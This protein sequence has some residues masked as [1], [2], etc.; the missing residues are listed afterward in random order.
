VSQ[1][2]TAQ[3]VAD[4]P[5][6]TRKRAGGGRG[7][8]ALATPN[9]TGP[10]VASVQAELARLGYDV[11]ADGVFGPL[12]DAAVRAFQTSAGLDS[13]GVVGPLTL[14]ALARAVAGVPAV[15][16]P[17][18]LPVEV[19]RRSALLK[20]LRWMIAQE[21]LI[22]YT[23]GDGRLQALATPY[24]SPLRTDCSGSI[25]IACAWAE[26]PDPNG[27]GLNVPRG[28]TGTMLTYCKKIRRADAQPGDF[29]VLGD[30]PGVHAC[31]VLEDGSDPLLF[32][33]GCEKGPL[34]VRLSDELSYHK[35]QS[36]HWLTLPDWTAPA[37]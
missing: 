37:A 29:L 35:G 12:T 9:V 30:Y 16:H 25:K 24:V 3:G 32:S 2:R 10:A 23:D 5:A 17:S 36:L 7:G 11:Q 28:Y 31:A 34:A 22:H 8:L 21:P 4:R 14:A 26:I 20:V 13:D 33:H 19:Q 27:L 15:Q 1:T 18:G 6:R